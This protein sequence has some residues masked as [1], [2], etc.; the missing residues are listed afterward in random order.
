MRVNLLAIA[1]YEGLK[2]LMESVAAGRPDICLTVRIGDLTDG[3]VL[4][5]QV[6]EQGFDVIVSRG[7]T[8]RLIEKSAHIPVVEIAISG[9]DMLR[10]IQLA[11]GYGGRFAIV[12]F[13]AITNHA[14]LIC[15]LTRDRTDIFT[16]DSIEQANICL[17]RLRDQ[18]YNLIVGDAVT[19]KLAYQMGLDGILITSGA[20]SVEAAFD[21]A[22]K[23]CSSL[24]ERKR[25]CAMFRS[26]IAESG[27]A[28]WVFDE[29]GHQCWKS[30][31]HGQW[32]DLTAYLKKQTPNLFKDSALSLAH[33]HNGEVYL[34]NGKTM[35][36]DGQ[37]C[38]VF[39]VNQPS[40]TLSGDDSWLSLNAM[41]EE[42]A[43]SFSALYSQ[44]SNMRSLLEQAR[45][46]SQSSSPILIMG[47]AGTGKDIIANAIHKA[48]RE[49]S[50]ALITLDALYGT[51]RRWDALL[52][53]V[54]SPLCQ[55]GYCIYFK[56]IQAIPEEFKW[57][58]VEYLRQAQ[59]HRRNRLLFAWQIDSQS[60]PYEDALCRFLLGELGSL[61]LSIP[62]LR[63]RME[64]MLSL[65]SIYINKFNLRY[66]KQITG[67]DE[68]AAS[69][70]RAHCWAHNFN[71]LQQVLREAVLLSDAP[72]ITSQVIHPLIKK[73]ENS[74][75]MP[76]R[77]LDLSGTLEQI[78]IQIMRAVL[79]QEN[80]NH[81]RAA[82]RLG[83]SRGTLWRKLKNA[84]E[85]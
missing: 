53:A 40:S 64:D 19:V 85:D 48:S 31:L 47:E 20:E 5:E 12:G 78:N 39:Y 45:T 80:N 74:A 28:I 71:D 4:V 37:P 51:P 75:P 29:S 17:G 76:D 69:L 16:I 7:G 43:A 46:F 52:E 60:E 57:R 55:M 33:K 66:G 2:E 79:A 50:N 22:V 83:V 77:A 14:R 11:H 81:S 18:G 38:A 59:V 82:A 13:A 58:L 41:A 6:Q 34:I 30:D 1:P 27:Q 54:Q 63:E 3:A 9:Y 24:S 25:E 21:Q 10:V 23:L 15:E 70:M 49:K 56:N 44:N 8:A 36:L 32:P 26:L 68:E 61:T 84:Q 62:P 42:Y 73:L 67:V 35:S 72:L 65:C